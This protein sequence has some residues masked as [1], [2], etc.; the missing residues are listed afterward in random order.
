MRDVRLDVVGAVQSEKLA[1]F[2]TVV[3]TFSGGV[4]DPDALFDLAYG[5][6]VFLRNLFFSSDHVDF[7]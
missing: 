2:V 6:F 7:F 1:I 4:G 5:F 3:E